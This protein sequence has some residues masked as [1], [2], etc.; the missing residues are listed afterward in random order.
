MRNHRSTVLGAALLAAMLL[1]AA[2]G[3]G[4]DGEPEATGDTGGEPTGQ[5]AEEPERGTIVVGVSGAFPENQAVAEMYGQVLENAG[6]T[7]ERQLD[8]GTREISDQALFGGE[9]DLKPEY[10]GFELPALDPEADTTGAAEEIAGLLAP[11]YAEQGVD[12][13][14]F[15]PANSTNAFVVTPETA[16]EHGLAT[17]SDLA[18]VAPDLTLGGPPECPERPFCLIGLEDV[19]GVEFGDFRP[20]DFGGPQTVAALENGAID[21]ALLFS[22][23]PTIS[24]KGWTS[25]EDDMELQAAGNFVGVIRSDVNNEEVTGLID[26]VTSSLTTEDML[27][28]VRRIAIDGE[29]TAAVATDYLTEQGLL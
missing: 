27:E 29:D 21:V 1:L 20:L 16:E 19:Y 3:S 25:L 7:V 13:L 26:G 5:T 12:V 2:C 8:L 4:E 10:L 14:A 15:S 17:V 18:P 6:Y 22:L 11:L 24:D 23:D 9:I 28:L